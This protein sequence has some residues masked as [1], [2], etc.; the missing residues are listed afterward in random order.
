MTTTMTSYQAVTRNLAQSLART[1]AQPRVAN[2]TAYFEKNGFS[3]RAS[4]RY[5]S[6]F[7]AEVVGFGASRVNR[8][9]KGETV[10][11][12]QLGYEVQSGALDGLGILLQGQNLTDE[13][14]VTFVAGDERRVIDYQS[15]GR[16]YLLGVSYKF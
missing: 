15:Y 9:A 8:I 14:F 12:A 13:P 6:G 11:D 2:D 5:R 4:M 16:R 1:A 7:L 10:V 3:A